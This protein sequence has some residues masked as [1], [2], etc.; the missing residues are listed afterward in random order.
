[1]S[2]RLVLLL[3]LSVAVAGLAQ[4][5][6]A[7]LRKSQPDQQPEVELRGWLSD[8]RLADGAPSVILRPAD[9]LSVAKAYGIANPP[10]VNF[11][12]HFL[13]V[14]VSARSRTGHFEL[15]GNGNLRIVASLASLKCC[16]EPPGSGFV[17]KSFRRSDVKTVEGLPLPKN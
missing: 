15:D 13:A 2:A 11:R 9:Y 8:S 4:A 6:P 5:A 10:K 16:E 3:V 12:T 1:M 17:I 7:P 14:H